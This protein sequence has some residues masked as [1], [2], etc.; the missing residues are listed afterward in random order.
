M[1]RQRVFPLDRTGET[2]VELSIAPEEYRAFFLP[3]APPTPPQRPPRRNDRSPPPH[4]SSTRARPRLGERC[5]P[6]P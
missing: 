4:T 2:A 3:G 6:E 1:L 5:P